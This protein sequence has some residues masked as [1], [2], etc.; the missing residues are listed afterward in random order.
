MQLQRW[1]IGFFYRIHELPKPTS[2]AIE[3]LGEIVA[4]PAASGLSPHLA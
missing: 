4:L 2:G 1:I 3:A